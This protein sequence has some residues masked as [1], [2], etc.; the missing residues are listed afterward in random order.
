[1]SFSGVEITHRRVSAVIL[2]AGTSSRMGQ[3]KQ[4][5]PMGKST[6]LAQ[7][8]ENLFAA[9]LAE[10][11]LVLGSSAEAIQGDLSR[12]VLARLSVVLNHSY[13]QGIAGSLRVGISSVDPCSSAAL[14]VLGDQPFIQA[15]TV[16][17]IVQGYRL[18]GAK[19][20]LPVYQGR[21]GNPVLL[22]RALF[23]EV[24]A[25]QGDVGAKAIF[26]RHL[27]EIVNVEVE[28]RGILLDVDEPADY[29]R[30]NPKQ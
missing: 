27:E 28:D 13:E 30:L 25:L 15:Q 24:M 2:A 19:I 8:I 10:I 3:P 29:Q 16:D 20:A 6:M 22:D 18:S 1:M 21:R 26:S 17:Q 11:I 9:S 14:I 23:P 7:T 12:P 5:L 4:L